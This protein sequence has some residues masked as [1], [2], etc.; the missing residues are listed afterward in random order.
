MSKVFPN[1]KCSTLAL[2]DSAAPECS[3]QFRPV[4]SGKKIH[5][6]GKAYTGSA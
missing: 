1:R 4:E 5:I 2:V 6:A 3:L